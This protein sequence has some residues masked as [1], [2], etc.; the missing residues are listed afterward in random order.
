MSKELRALLDELEMLKTEVRSL[1]GE[2]K[3]EE[4]EKKMESVR[5]LQTK[6]KIAQDLSNDDTEPR[7]DP[8]KVIDPDE[9]EE[10]KHYRT[11]FVKMLKRR[12]LSGT[13]ID[14]LEKRAMTQ[15]VPE[16][17]GVLV[18]QDILTKIHELKRAMVDLSRLINVESVTTLTGSRV[19]EKAADMTPF[20]ELTEM[21]DIEDMDNPKF[22][23]VSYSVKARAG[24]LPLSN[25]LLQDSDQN[26]LAYVYKWIA[27]KSVL[28]RNTLIATLLGTLSKKD[29]A[30]LDAIKKVLNVELDPSIALGA[31]CLTNQDGYHY[32]DT[33]KDSDGRYLL[34]DDITQ[35]GGKLLFGKQLFVAP[36]KLIKTTGTTT[37][38]APLIIGDL[39]ELATLF[40]RQTYEID[41]TKEGGKAFYRNS[42]DV[43]V[44]ERSD[45]QIIDSGAAVYGNLTVEGGV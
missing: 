6:I 40:D 4:A 16:D 19:I 45:I 43:R 37:K 5:A 11:A 27:K 36:N 15:G 39:E 26:I 23:T 41:A 14:L 1:L 32:L 10:E 22:V 8:N 35:P 28:T 34:K 31:V 13:E 24:I 20:A 2:N 25:T 33:L 9:A 42:T 38:K 17:G 29:L 21:T 7:N 3:V 12:N 18:P 30:D 44:I